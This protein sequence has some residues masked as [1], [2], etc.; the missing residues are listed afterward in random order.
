MPDKPLWLDRLPHAIE[1]LESSSLPWVDRRTIEDLLGVRRRRAQQILSPLAT[2]SNGHT[3]LVEKSTLIQHLR[4]LAI[5]ELTFY[6]NRRRQRLWRELKKEHDRWV[7]APPVLVEA[8]PAMLQAVYKKDFAGLPPG[9]EL[10]PGRIAV[11]FETAEEAL[12]KLL[13]LAL[14]IGQNRDAFEELVQTGISP[15]ELLTL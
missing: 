14:A 8:P 4:R 12:Q 1:T 15:H 9:V 10:T 5:G 2:Q 6:E 7:E 3:A 13:A 11:T